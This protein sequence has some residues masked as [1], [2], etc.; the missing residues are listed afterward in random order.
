M[1]SDGSEEF[2]IVLDKAQ[3]GWRNQLSFPFFPNKQ[4]S[5]YVLEASFLMQYNLEATKEHS[6]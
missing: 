4:W 6:Q 1:M 2:S 5:L 3:T